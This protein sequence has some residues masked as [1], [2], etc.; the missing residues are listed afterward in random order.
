[1]KNKLT[2]LN[3]HLF[4]QIERL[5]EEERVGEKLIEEIGRAK[6]VGNIAKNIIDNARLVF[7]A[8]L[9][10]DDT[11]RIRKL[12]EMLGIELRKEDD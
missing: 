8:Q 9:A 1:M 11:M 7:D 2:N 3:D 6:A 12:P 4:A 10:Y 5:S